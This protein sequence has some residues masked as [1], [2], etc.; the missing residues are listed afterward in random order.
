MILYYSPGACSL[1]AHI[2]LEQAGADFTLSRVTLAQGEHRTPDYLK[3][4]P[5]ARVPALDVDGQVITEN[6][7]ILNFLASRFHA[8]GSVPLDD[9]LIAARCNELLGWCASTVHIAFAEVWRPERFSPDTAVHAAIEQGGRAALTGFFTEIEGLAGEGWT[10]G[11]RLSAVDCYF[12]VFFRWGG[13]IGVDM[14]AFPR[15]ADLARRVAER[16]AVGRALATEG[17]TADDFIAAR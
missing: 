15:W 4:N 14:A 16:P 1:V 2:A 9:P 7:A 17:Y 12:L 6:I 8:D 10:V 11:D 3:I 13:R 5:H